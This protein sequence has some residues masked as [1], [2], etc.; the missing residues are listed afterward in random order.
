MTAAVAFIYLI[1]ELLTMVID[2]KID[3]NDKSLMSTTGSDA[4]ISSEGESFESEG[5]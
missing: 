2:L 3:D 4:D 5:E 1:I